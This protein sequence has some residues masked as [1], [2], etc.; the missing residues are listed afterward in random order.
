MQKVCESTVCVQ[1]HV[2]HFFLRVTLKQGLYGSW[3]TWNFI[4]DWHFPG[5]E[6]AGKRPLG[7]ES[8]GN[9]LNSIKKIHV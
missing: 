4:L 3:K 1:I 9:L 7:L 5:L 2:E 6:S 8:S